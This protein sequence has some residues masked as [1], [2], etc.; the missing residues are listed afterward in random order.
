MIYS[1]EF[2]EIAENVLGV[3][4]EDVIFTATLYGYGEN[5]SKSELLEHALHIANENGK[6]DKVIN[7]K[8]RIF[9]ISATLIYE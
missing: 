9:A 5:A 6:Y 4:F 1:V 3:K 2:H 8:Y 7:C